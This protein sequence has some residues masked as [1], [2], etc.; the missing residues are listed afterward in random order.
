MEAEAVKPGKIRQWVPVGALM[1][2]AFVFNT[3][4]FIPI[5]LLSD[6]GRDFH[7]SEAKMGMIISVYAWVVALMSLP[8]MVAASGMSGRRLML[9][10]VGGFTVFQVAS[11]LSP[12]YWWLMASRIGVACTHAVFW[13]VVPL[14][15]VKTA[16]K[17]KEA[18][19]LSAVVSGASVAM[20]VGLPIGRVIGLYLS[21]RVTFATIAGVGT[22]VFLAFI[23][24]FPQVKS[25][26]RFQVSQL[27]S[28]FRNKMLIWL[29]VYTILI[30]TAYF[31][32]YGYIEPFLGQIA[33]VQE[34]VVT[35][36]LV[37]MGVG[38]LCGSVIFAKGFGWM[39]KTLFATASLVLLSA[40]AL[41]RPACIS[42]PTIIAVCMIMSCSLTVFNLIN[43]EI[44]VS[45][46]K[47]EGS[48]VAMATY[49]GLFNLGIGSGTYTGGLVITHISMAVIGYIGA[50]I[51]I[52]GI[53]V[54]TTTL[55][56]RL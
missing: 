27:P 13:G 45:R 32:A 33:K 20:I 42:L 48:T 4:E 9:L 37:M 28:L 29:Y 14:L 38:G 40:L 22:L 30:V 36:V 8:L 1:L 15:A 56:R 54:G 2:S 12:G 25:D 19:A 44:I 52:L 34:D 46:I 47:G 53:A 31:T 55:L 50:A 21:W 5:G 3:S 49:S 41:L 16:P 23:L 24:A 6:I 35:V 39:P 26:G 18:A 11:A 43:Q 17:G 10:L 7:A 51:A